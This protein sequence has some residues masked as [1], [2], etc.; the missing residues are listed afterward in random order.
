MAT[1]TQMRSDFREALGDRAM[2]YAD[3]DVD[4][5][6]NRAWQYGLPDRVPDLFGPEKVTGV[7]TTASSETLDLSDASLRIARL[8]GP[9]YVGGERVGLWT[10]PHVFW[11]LYDVDDLSEGLPAAALVSGPRTVILRQVPDQAYAVIVHAL[12]YNA[13][14]TADGVTNEAMAD[15]VVRGSVVREA[16]QQ[17]YDSV[18]ERYAALFSASLDQ[19]RS[20][21][22]A[23][24]RAP[25]AVADF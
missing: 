3:A 16:A 14:L 11:Q 8:R 19:L 15:A 18:V 7:T 10:D 9:L 25:L 1:L 17:G 21:A 13:A 20:Q 5:R 2:D 22:S 12:R 23:L 4:T 6:L 24:P